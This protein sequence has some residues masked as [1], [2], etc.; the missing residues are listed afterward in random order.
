MAASA[1]SVDVRPTLLVV[2]DDE[3]VRT[4][5]CWQLEAEGYVVRDAADGNAAW[6]A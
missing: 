1:A 6:L 5:V 4:V 3:R 2:D